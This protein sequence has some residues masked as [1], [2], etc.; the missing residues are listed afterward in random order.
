M[1]KNTV[2]CN[3][4]KF[5]TIHTGYCSRQLWMRNALLN[6]IN[7]QQDIDKIYLCVKDPYEPIYQYLIKRHKRVGLECFSDQRLP[8]NTQ[9]MWMMS[10]E[11]FKSTNQEEK[12]ATN[13][14]SDIEFDYRNVRLYR[15][16]SVKPY[17]S[18]VIDDTL[19]SKNAYRF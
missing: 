4:H 7:H 12:K 1:C 18:L 11:V 15:N 10:Q 9:M 17:S 5:L 16:V 2:V 13:Y 3:D 8:W 14:S 6:L 19:S